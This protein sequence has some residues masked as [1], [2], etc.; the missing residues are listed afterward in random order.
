M[1]AS[2]VQIILSQQLFFLIMEN[3]ADIKVNLLTQT[4]LI[5]EVEV[6]YKNQEK[7]C[8]A[9][10]AVHHEPF[11]VRI[12]LKHIKKDLEHIVDFDLAEQIKIRFF[13]G[14]VKT[15]QDKTI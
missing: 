9:L 5:E 12:L 10:S 14:T 1:L 13:D 8:G 2:N 4:K 7:Y 3:T 11:E 15:Y 6:A